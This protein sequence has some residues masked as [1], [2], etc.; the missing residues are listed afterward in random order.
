ME[1][2]GYAQGVTQRSGTGLRDRFEPPLYG[3][4]LDPAIRLTT[5]DATTSPQV[6]SVTVEY[7]LRPVPIWRHEMTIDV[8]AGAFSVSG[9]QGYGDPLTPAVALLTLRAMAGAS[10]QMALADLWAVV[11]DV[12][13]PVDGVALRAAS[14]GEAGYGGEVPLLVDVVCVEQQQRSAGH[15]GRRVHVPLGRPQAPHLGAGPPTRLG[16]GSMTNGAGQRAEHRTLGPGAPGHAGRPGLGGA[17]GGAPGG[18]RP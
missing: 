14:G 17:P 3:R 18:Q 11:Y 4:G 2:F 12:S 13:I 6:Y 1:P 5:V 16:A 8:S 7:D 15:L 10:G 9:Q